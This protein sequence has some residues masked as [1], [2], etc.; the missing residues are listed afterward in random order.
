MKHKFFLLIIVYLVYFKITE[1]LECN[2]SYPIL[3]GEKCELTY[4]EEEEYKLRN[5]SVNNFII[6][7]QWLNNII[8]VG[9]KNYRYINFVTNS[10]NE[11][12]FETSAH[13]ESNDRIFFGI[14]EDGSPFFKDSNGNKN[15]IKKKNLSD[16]LYESVVGYIKI[17]SEDINYKDKEYIITIGKIGT[18]TEI[19][20]YNQPDEEVQT[21][22]ESSLFGTSIR[23]YISSTINL[24]EEGIHYFFFC[25]IINSS[26]YFFSLI[27][28]KF[29]VESGSKISFSKESNINYET[30]EDKRIVSFFI[31][32]KKIIVFFYY[33]KQNSK[34]AISLLNT[35]LK[36]LKEEDFYLENASKKA[37]FYKCIHFK[38]EI[39]IFV[40]ILGEDDSSVKIKIFEIMD[41]YS[42][43]DYIPELVEFLTL[44][45]NRKD[46][47]I[48][49]IVK[50]SDY[51][52]CFSACSQDKD[53]LLFELIN[54][55]E[56]KK[57]NI[58]YYIIPIFKLYNFK[59][60][61]E[62]R[63][64]RYNQHLAF[65]FSYC[66]Q[67]SCIYDDKDEHFSAIII[68][69]YP[70]IKEGPS[71][72]LINYFY[73]NDINYLLVNFT[74][75][76]NIDNNIFG[77]VIYGIK[78]IDI[79]DTQIKLFST[80]YNKEI[81]KNDI[82]AQD[83]L[84]KI[85]SSNDEYNEMDY[86]IKYQLIITEPDYEEYNQY[87]SF[88]YKENDENEK[89]SFIKTKYA[90]KV[91]SYNIKIKNELTGNCKSDFCDLC[92][93]N[94]TNYCIVCTDNYTFETNENYTKFKKCKED[95]C[96]IKMI[97]GNNC[98]N[99]SLSFGKYI[100]IYQK[101]KNN[102]T[103]WKE[104]III[105]TKNVTYQ[106]SSYNEQKFFESRFIS[107]V[108]IGTC[109]D[110]F[111]KKYDINEE[112]IIIKSD[113]KNEDNT[114]TYV[115]FEL[116]NPYILEQLDLNEC[117]EDYV[118]INAPVYLNNDVE[119][120]YDSLNK[121]GYNL[122]NIYDPFYNDV[123]APYTTLNKTDIIAEDRKELYSYYGNISLC[124][125]NGKFFSYSSLTKKALCQC[126]IKDFTI[127]IDKMD[128]LI[129]SDMFTKK[130][131]Y[132]IFLTT[133]RNSNFLVLK[134]FEFAFDLKTIFTNIGRIIMSLFLIIFIII[135][136]IH[137]IKE[138]NLINE[139]IIEIANKK[140]TKKSKNKVKLKDRNKNS[141]D[142]EI[143]TKIN[144]NKKKNNRISQIV[145]IR[146]N[147][148]LSN[149]S[150][151]KKNKDDNII[152]KKLKINSAL[153]N[154]STKNYLQK[155]PSSKIIP[156]ISIDSKKNNL[157]KSNRFLSIVKTYN[158]QELNTMDYKIAL[159][160][161][162][163]TFLQYYWSLLKKKHLIL[164]SFMPNNDYNLML[165]KINL[166]LVSFS[167]YFSING[168]FFNDNTMHKIYFNGGKFSII[169][170]IPQILF[171]SIISI[172]INIILKLLALTENDIL[173]F[174]KQKKSVEID[175]KSK[176]IINNLKTKIIIF[177]I[178]S[179]I[180]L[181]FFWYF[182][183]CFCGAFANSQIFLIKDTLTSF[184]ISMIYPF[185]INF[186]PAILRITALR[187]NKN[188][189]IYLYKISSI[190]SLI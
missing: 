118:I 137:F 97:I 175:K 45:D 34:Y 62:I 36:K 181:L 168:F 4:C 123:C 60:L 167:L 84:I 115:Q 20:N 179:I 157:C 158:D 110:F 102:L 117:K 46:Y 153:K 112:L 10:N 57:Y 7:T 61:W 147:I 159:K 58:R 106:M 182:I 92:F 190:I 19:F 122:F 184:L 98:I 134:C 70:N 136:I 151:I 12:F 3:K 35:E 29:M 67:E 11:T 8:Q 131:I 72:N 49:D 142:I 174:K 144:V 14:K 79:S 138:R 178:I 169:F 65:G 166:F 155:F 186:L 71:I 154:E 37:L 187:N 152:K 107:N 50:I 75:N 189:R 171:S 119:I 180:L 13:P 53:I 161:D 31:T 73:E 78:I 39:G 172:F 177:Y 183:S 140:K 105:Q 125:N 87:P 129:I 54:F 76:V 1:E 146:E 96:S 173:N 82:I 88:I 30:E 89:A 77:L 86:E 99:E 56:E 162:K 143:N 120:L 74:E 100:E 93:K 164:F 156:F 132:N 185:G 47:N 165:I 128:K 69:S 21:I 188:N 48:N 51:L 23:T 55:Y 121:S 95:G 18:K 25:A 101:L 17:N 114:K 32:E 66:N 2:S 9:T 81:N 27:K 24:T 135:M 124:Q 90:G 40:Y 104:N 59:I 44:I 139:M 133:V 163:R 176:Q 63:L 16:K 6:R 41:D 145:K 130:G 83:D 42:L 103:N 80:K 68:F 116:Y 52:V 141:N 5:C 33:C 170:Q 148:K 28:F 38:K 22:D 91:G 113:I 127:N 15:Y 160:Y 94:D 43:K 26:G 64:H 126:N 109:E 111:K 108:D 149:P 85:K 150:K